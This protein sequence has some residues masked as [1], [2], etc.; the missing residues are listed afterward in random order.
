MDEFCVTYEEAHKQEDKKVMYLR[1]SMGKDGRRGLPGPRGP[2]GDPGPPG[3]KGKPGPYGPPGPPGCPGRKGPR[4][5]HGPQG[6][7]GLCGTFGP[8]GQRG[9]KG[10]PGGPPGQPGRPGGPG[11]QGSL[12]IVGPKADKG[13]LGVKGPKGRLGAAGSQGPPGRPGVQGAGGIFGTTGPCGPT[14]SKGPNGT[15]DNNF[16]FYV[17]KFWKADDIFNDIPNIDFVPDRVDFNDLGN[18]EQSYSP[19]PSA[20]LTL[21]GAEISKDPDTREL[22]LYLTFPTS[23][24]INQI[25]GI[26]PGYKVS[27]LPLDVVTT[28]TFAAELGKWKVTFTFPDD[29]SFMSYLNQGVIFNI[30]VRWAKGILL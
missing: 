19:P 6:P 15:V 22:F 29:T 24:L 27:T 30:N 25:F 13:K 12:G 11:E 14:G 21:E 20:I 28:T 10:E 5:M 7:R 8:A 17:F 1:G 2:Q 4:G 18:F 3:I 26:F 16:T 9:P 23:A